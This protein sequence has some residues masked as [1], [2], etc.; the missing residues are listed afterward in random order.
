MI[1]KMQGALKM[2]T[3]HIAFKKISSNKSFVFKCVSH[4]ESRITYHKVASSRPVYY[5]IFELFDQRS[6]YICIKFPL[7]KPSEN[8][9]TVLSTKTIYCFT[10]FN[11]VGKSGIYWLLMKGKSYHYWTKYFLIDC[12]YLGHTIMRL[13][14]LVNC[15]HHYFIAIV[16]F[17]LIFTIVYWGWPRTE[18]CKQ[19]SADIFQKKIQER[20]T[21]DNNDQI[22]VIIRCLTWC[23]S[24]LD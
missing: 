19:S 11:W 2:W 21:K 3:T 5:S 7:H 9:N 17:N 15:C 6:Q 13:V 10:V 1:T 20:F 23:N 22:W 14:I 18:M 16:V 8:L 12:L 24:C 4:F